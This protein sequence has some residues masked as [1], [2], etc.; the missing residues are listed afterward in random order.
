VVCGGCSVYVV[1]SGVYGYPYGCPLHMKS[2]PGF[3]F[4]PNAPA[5]CVIFAPL[6]GPLYCP[7]SNRPSRVPVVISHK[8]HELTLR[9][10]LDI[11]LMPY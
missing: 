1:Y 5:F 4:S 6:D 3:F 7:L 11:H 8:I 9:V 2:P 10:V